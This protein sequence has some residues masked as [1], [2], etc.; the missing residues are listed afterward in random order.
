VVGTMKC[1]PYGATRSTTGSMVTDKLFTG[2]QRE[3]EAVS[4]VGLYDYGARF[5]STAGT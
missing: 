1:Y 5:Y 3:P 4:A 2:Q